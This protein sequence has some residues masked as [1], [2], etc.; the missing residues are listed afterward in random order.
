MD[1]FDSTPSTNI[2][3][4][5]HLKIP[6]MKTVYVTSLSYHITFHKKDISNYTEQNVCSTEIFQIKVLKKLDDSNTR[7]TKLDVK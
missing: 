7:F 6:L 2:K 3:I 1:L 4:T 5:D